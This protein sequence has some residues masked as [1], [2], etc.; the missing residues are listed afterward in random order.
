[1]KNQ[2]RTKITIETRQTIVVRSLRDTRTWCQRCLDE[3]PAL[4]QDSFAQLLQIPMV[5]LF[6]L[7]ES[8]QLHAIEAAESP[9]ICCNS[10]STGDTQTHIQIEGERQ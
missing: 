6:G 8:G 4:S 2:T 5:T 1:M 9:M 3:V 10:L 7:L